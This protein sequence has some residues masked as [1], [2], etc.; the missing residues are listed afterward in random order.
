LVPH[1]LALWTATAGLSGGSGSAGQRHRI[2]GV[3]ELSPV[4]EQHPDVYR[5]GDHSDK[6]RHRQHGYDEG[7]P[8]LRM[9]PV[10]A[11]LAHWNTS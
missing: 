9:P 1:S 10:N 11:V 4:P 3:L 7:P 2:G 8:P 5:H 6:H